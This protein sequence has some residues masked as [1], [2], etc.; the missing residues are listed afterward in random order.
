MTG[1]RSLLS[2]VIVCWATALLLAPGCWGAG[3]TAQDSGA[4]WDLKDVHFTDVNNG[5]AV[6][7]GGMLRTKDGGATWTKE[8]VEVGRRGLAAVYFANPQCGWA[9]GGGQR[10]GLVLVTGDGGANWRPVQAPND[11]GSKGE[12]FAVHFPDPANG[13]AV[14]MYGVIMATKDGGMTWTQQATQVTGEPLVAV[15]FVD[16]LRGW[17]VAERQLL[18]TTDGGANWQVVTPAGLPDRG[19]YQGLFFASPEC[20]WLGAAGGKIARTTDGAKTWTTVQTPGKWWTQDIHFVDANLGWAVGGNGQILYT[21][22]SGAT[23]TL[24]EFPGGQF[25]AVHFV[26]AKNGWI[27]GRDGQILHTTTGWE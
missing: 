17:A 5:W 24:Q 18:Q 27:V 22:D 14:G 6:G 12:F 7:R 23:W 11:R 19:G 21:K 4:N 16:A 8:E 3:W 1:Q 9:V 10:G 13:W 15:R 2:R 26:D 20:G 25:N